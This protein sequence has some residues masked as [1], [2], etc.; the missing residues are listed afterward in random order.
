M[1]KERLCQT[2]GKPYQSKKITHLFCSRRCFK[3]SYYLRNRAIILEERRNPKRPLKTCLVCGTLCLLPFDPITNPRAYNDWQCHNCRAT[4]DLIWRWQNS[5]N[6]FQVIMQ[7][8]RTVQVVFS[9]S[10][11][12]I[13][14]TPY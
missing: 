13:T 9:F 2:C 7:E 6:S 10:A 5:P 3:R 14:K 8:L 11:T 12:Y 4:N 1:T